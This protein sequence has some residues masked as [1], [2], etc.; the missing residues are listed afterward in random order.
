MK[1]HLR[2][3]NVLV[4]GG[5]S[6]IGFAAAK[7][8]AEE[9]CGVVIAGRHLARLEAARKALPR[10]R[11]FCLQLDTAEVDALPAK[12]READALLG[13]GL[14]GLVNAAGVGMNEVLHRDDWA[15]WD[16]TGEEWDQIVGVDLKGAFFMMRD[17]VDFLLSNH[18]KGNIVNVSSN[19]AC[20]DIVNPYGAS[21]LSLLK[22]TRSLG[23]RYGQNGI[24]IN[25]VAPG[26][27]LTRMIASYAHTADQPYPRHAIGRFILPEEM[28][29][30]MGFLM[31]TVGETICGHTIVVDGGDRCATL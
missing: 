26:A 28:A 2:V 11:V 6:G 30:V 25:G 12:I 15:G 5:A 19:A 31:S 22:L 8:L 14:D 16:I 20:M 1:I 9:G 7:M 13:G 27:T 18:R 29:A 21:K 23:K 10:D 4:T 24:I 3:H 17:V